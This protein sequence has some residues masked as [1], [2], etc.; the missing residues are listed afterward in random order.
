VSASLNG[1]SRKARKNAH[2]MGPTKGWIIQNSTTARTP[3]AMSAN[4]R[5]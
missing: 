3:A 2:S 5:G 4:T 1:E